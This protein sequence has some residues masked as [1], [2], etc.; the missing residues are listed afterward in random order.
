MWRARGWRID[1]RFSEAQTST[2]MN[3]DA[4]LTKIANVGFYRAATPEGT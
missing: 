4:D 2:I 3:Y 1:R